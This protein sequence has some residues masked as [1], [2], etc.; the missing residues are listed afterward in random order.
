MVVLLVIAAF[1]TF[2]PWAGIATT[3]AIVAACFAFGYADDIHVWRVHRR[4]R[5]IRKG[6]RA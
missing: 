3:V 5:A 2:G 4:L 6:Q 1:G